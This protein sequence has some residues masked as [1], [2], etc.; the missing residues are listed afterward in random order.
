MTVRKGLFQRVRDAFTK[1]SDKVEFVPTSAMDRL[2]Q[3]GIRP[4]IMTEQLENRI[5]LMTHIRKLIKNVYTGTSLKQQLDAIDEALPLILIVSQPWGRGHDVWTTFSAQ[6]RELR[7]MPA[8]MDTMIEEFLDML[9]HGWLPQDVIT[10]TP[11]V[12]FTPVAQGPQ[13]DLTQFEVSTR[14]KEESK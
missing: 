9:N 1:P 3:Q 14:P 4:L 6:F 8:F 5:A 10:P 12:M 11:I 2:A 7:T 13:Y